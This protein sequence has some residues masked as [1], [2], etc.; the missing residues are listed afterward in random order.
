MK[1]IYAVV[2]LAGLMLP[3]WKTPPKQDGWFTFGYPMTGRTYVSFFTM[4]KSGIQKNL[5]KITEDGHWTRYGTDKEIYEFFASQAQD[6][7]KVLEAV[8]G[9]LQRCQE[10]TK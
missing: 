4:S 8:R 3:L 2:L 6:Q 10:R 1:A 7:G 5:L 9:E